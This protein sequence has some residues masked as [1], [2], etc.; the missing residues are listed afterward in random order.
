MEEK[1]FYK[2]GILGYFYQFCHP[3]NYQSTMLLTI[4]LLTLTTATSAVK[5]TYNIDEALSE[6]DKTISMYDELSTQKENRIDSLKRYCI[7]GVNTREQYK[8]HDAIFEEY[9]TWDS[10]SAYTYAYRK[11]DIAENH[12]DPA[13]I[14]DAIIDI[15]KRY[16]ISGMHHEALSA[17]HKV[18]TITAKRYYGQSQKL[19]YMHFELYNWLASVTSD[20]RFKKYYESEGH[21]SI[22]RWA[23]SIEPDSSEYFIG[24]LAANLVDA[25][26]IHTLK[27]LEAYMLRDGL[28][29]HEYAMLYYYLGKVYKSRND[30]DKAMY[31]YTKSAIYDLRQG[32]KE[33][34]SLIQVAKYCHQHGDIK[35]A[36]DY[37]MKCEKDA[38]K[39]D[40]KHRIIQISDMMSEIITSYEKQNRQKRN[41]LIGT[42]IF[43]IFSI[44]IIAFVLI[45]LHRSYHRLSEVNAVKDT[46]VGEFL[47]MF[48][49]H[50]NSLEKYRSNLR[51][52]SKQKDFDEL[53]KELRSEKFIDE[54][55]DFLMKKFDKTFLGLFPN[56]ISDLN[57]LLQPDKH[58]G[59]DLK[60][61]ELTNE[62]RIF[63]LI[64]LGITKSQRISKFLRLSASTVYNYRTKLNNAAK[65][66]RE[67]FEHRLKHIGIWQD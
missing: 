24:K 41:E 19:H 20:I 4:L 52:I 65:C 30:E 36:Y 50:M 56:F 47:S 6:L 54:E 43:L 23:N 25:N 26:D 29:I 11:M 58:I 21:K 67:D 9:M 46:Y 51:K 59:Q 15:S 17:M 60:K 44:V 57:A 55:W 38:I 66:K 27:M 7:K 45:Q 2:I 32:S 35:R 34:S 1:N 53:Q 5:E 18:D 39:C 64:R 22:K 3:N 14:N 10:D 31:Y 49:D 48:S 61:G 12:G 42:I 62:L 13:L 37:I 33:Y 63:A 16:I 28:S 8:A 40:A